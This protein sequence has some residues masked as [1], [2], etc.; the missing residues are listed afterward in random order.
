V[1]VVYILLSAQ[2]YTDYS[3]CSEMMLN[4]DRPHVQV[5][6]ELDGVIFG[7]PLRS[8]INHPHAVWTD[9]SN[10]CGLD[11]SKAIVITD[12]DKYIGS[13]QKPVFQ[14]NALYKQSYPQ[15]NE[16]YSSKTIKKTKVPLTCA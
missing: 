8:N 2:F 4:I 9:R 11:L 16:P 3:H 14:I 12:V 5:Q 7:I 10:K 6:I 13:T 1:D 15:A